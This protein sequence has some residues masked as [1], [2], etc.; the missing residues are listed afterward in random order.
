MKKQ[1]K[2]I[3]EPRE[4]VYSKEIKN[5]EKQLQNAEFE[6]Q[7][8]ATRMEQISQPQYM[9]ELKEKNITLTHRIKRMERSKKSMEVQQSH[10]EKKMG[11]VIDVGESDIMQEIHRITAEIGNINKQITEA[12]DILERRSKALHDHTSR[13]ENAKSEWQKVENDAHSQGVELNVQLKKTNKEKFLELE[14]KKAALLKQVNLLKSRNTYSLSDY[15]QK[16]NSLQK[17]LTGTAQALQSKNE[18]LYIHAIFINRLWLNKKEELATLVISMKN[19]CAN[20]VEALNKKAESQQNIKEKAKNNQ[21]P[22]EEEIDEEYKKVNFYLLNKIGRSCNKSKGISE[23]NENSI[24]M[25]KIQEREDF[26]KS[27]R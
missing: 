12:D 7:V 16:K 13:L 17:M 1:L 3:N 22:A 25:E 23:C 5:A 9:E 8:M 19:S 10:R 21:K 6:Y 20:A 2:K 14:E 11:K 26:D 24:F 15:M 27:K 18:Y 4:E